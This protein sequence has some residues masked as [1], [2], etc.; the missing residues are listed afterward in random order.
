MSNAEML[1]MCVRFIMENHEL[2]TD[3][4]LEMLDKL[5]N[6]KYGLAAAAAAAEAAAEAAVARQQATE[7]PLPPSPPP[8]PEQH[9]WACD[10]CGREWTSDVC[11]LCGRDSAGVLPETD[12]SVEQDY[13]CR[14]DDYQTSLM[15]WCDGSMCNMCYKV[16][17]AQQQAQQCIP[18]IFPVQELSEQP[19]TDGED[20]APMAS[21]EPKKPKNPIYTN[22][23]WP[24]PIAKVFVQQIRGNNPWQ[25]YRYK[26]L[27]TWPSDFKKVWLSA[28]NTELKL[29]HDN[30]M[31]YLAYRMGGLTPGQLL[32]KTP[33][34][35]HAKL[36]GE[37][38][39]VPGYY[40]KRFYYY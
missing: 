26:G 15:C 17:E 21:P 31:R 27:E 2:V 20:E 39:G 29:T 18:Q 8:E 35:V 30:C 6:Y 1:D 5:W 38:C 7:K 16:A 14:D 4:H 11:E 22:Y 19:D 3:E 36:I 25:H 32:E 40:T 10:W 33:R 28:G 34:E 13:S 23:H 9:L 24:S 37:H 12:E